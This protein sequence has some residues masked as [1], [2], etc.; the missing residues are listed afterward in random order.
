M[1]G[2]AISP[3]R[4]RDRLVSAQNDILEEKD[5]I[6]TAQKML[7]F[8]RGAYRRARRLPRIAAGIAVL[9][10]SA[11]IVYLLASRVQQQG[12]DTALLD[13]RSVA[14]GEWIFGSPDEEKTLRFPDGSDLSL[15]RRTGVRIHSLHPEGAHLSLEHG[16]LSA[17]I[18]HKERTAWS[19]TA[20][21]FTVEVTGTR[22]DVD[23]SP[24]RQSFR[25]DLEEGTVRVTGPMLRDG[26]LMRAGEKLLASLSEERIEIEDANH[27]KTVIFNGEETVAE[28]GAVDDPPALSPREASPADTSPDP[29]AGKRSPTGS[30][31]Q[32]LA[33]SGRYREAMVSAKRSGVP[34]I[35]KNESAATLMLLGDTARRSGDLDVAAKA[36]RVV[37]RRFARTPHASGA[38]FSL[39]LMAFDNQRNYQAAAKWFAS[40]T[41]ATPPG[42]F[43]REAAG[44]LMESLDRA[45][46][47]EGARTA[48]RRYLTRYPGGPHARL[49][50]KL[51]T[52][53]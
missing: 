18:V 24:E 30:K 46:D 17:H 9:A 49:A 52:S 50:E 28:R 45:G 1:G 21:P 47:S 42:A 51:A 14:V 37:R 20:G 16:G 43:T 4:F 2:E 53:N 6:G 29:A 22:F 36:Y 7:S 12:P 39:G 3:S 44:R 8:R 41:E 19:V 13:G 35:L 10:V 11:T 23:W 34:D 32:S 15:E 31:W 27:L 25:L 38:A 26:R 40:C 33:K 48:A 5:Y